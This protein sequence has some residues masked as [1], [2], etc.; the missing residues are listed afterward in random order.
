MLHAPRW[1]VVAA[2][3]AIAVEAPEVGA[4]SAPAPLIL[5]RDLRID[6]TEQDLSPIGWLLVARNGTIVAAQPQDN[7]LRYFDGKGTPL[8][9]FGRGGAGPGEFKSLGLRGWAGDTLWVGDIST[10][11]LT[12]VGP[13]RKLATT[14]PFPT[15]VTVGP[16]AKAPLPSLAFIIPQSYQRD[17]SMLVSA[18]AGKGADWTEWTSADN[19]DATPILRVSGEGVLDRIVAWR[20][21]FHCSVSIE[22]KGGTGSMSIPFCATPLLAYSDDGGGVAQ[23]SMENATG[24]S[25]RYQLTVVRDKGDTVFSRTYAYAP[26]AIPRQAADSA[27]AARS[28]MQGGA[29]IDAVKK[30]TIPPTYPP[31]SRVLIGRDATVWLESYPTGATRSWTVL[32]EHGNPVATATVPR[33]VALQVVSLDAV[34]AIETDEDGLQSIVRFAVSRR[35]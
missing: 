31:V 10:R 35:G 24:R 34:W 3:S 9:T 32:D 28:R 23:V 14:V 1:A 29:W 2:L 22:I 4:Q 11:R 15:A 30:M 26:Q 19:K 13:D 12:L 21:S 27:I 18:L 33:N 17:G 16:S 20:P 6:A 8:G 5:T 25:A 7:L